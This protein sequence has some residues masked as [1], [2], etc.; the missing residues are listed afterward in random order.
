VRT[1]SSF[2]ATTLD[3]FYA[4]PNDEFDWPNVDDEFYRFSISQMNDVDALLFG[5]RT[6]EMMA[7]YWPTPAARQDD[8]TVARMM[9]SMPKIVFSTTL[10]RA[11][12]ENTRLL[13]GDLAAEVTGLKEQPGK[14]LIV[15]GSQVLT[16]NLIR[17]GLL[18]ELRVIVNPVTLGQGKSMFR[19]MSGRVRLRLLQT[20][21]F[22]GSGN[23]L[24]TYRPLTSDGAAA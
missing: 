3:G 7:S 18:D 2:I 23:V 19:S 20:R 24:L 13:T 14:D 6:Y 22:S 17:L 12:W 4:G 21:V 15:F 9:N 16:G 5:R 1:L 8:P 11:D 10:E